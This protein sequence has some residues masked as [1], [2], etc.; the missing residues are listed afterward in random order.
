MPDTVRKPLIMIAGGAVI[1]TGLALLPLPGPGW[2]II[3]L[4]LAILATEFAWAKRL[5]EWAIYTF[6]SAFKSIRKKNNKK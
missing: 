3:F 4:G 6:K 1:L 5:K 2:A